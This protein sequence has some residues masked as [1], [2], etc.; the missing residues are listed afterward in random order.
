MLPQWVRGR[1]L[2][3]F[4][5]VICGT[6]AVGSAAWGEAAAKFGVDR[7]LL[8]A[9]A[10]ALL[11]IPLTW[12]WRLHNA[13]ALDLTP[14]LH[15]KSPPSV[16]EIPDDRGPVLVKIDYR[17]DPKDRERFLR[18]VDELGEQRRRDAPSPGAC[19]KTLRCWAGTRKP[20]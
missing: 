17:I 6:V 5:A 2:A 1:G 19:S 8:A 7:A 13:E 11:G 3:I 14:S 20:T 16:E 4:L 18:A 9:A 15:Y 12:P 10:G